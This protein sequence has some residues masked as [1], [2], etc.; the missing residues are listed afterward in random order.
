MKNRLIKVFISLV[1]A[2]VFFGAKNVGASAIVIEKEPVPT[3]I[4]YGEPLF[5]SKLIGGKANVEGAFSWANGEQL[6]EVGEHSVEVIFSADEVS[7]SPVSFFV[8]ITVNKRRV[9]IKFEDE[10]HKQYDDTRDIDLPNYIVGG[11]RKGDNVYVNGKLKGTLESGLV[12]SNTNVFLSGIELVGEKKDNYYLDLSGFS[13]KVYP[14]YIE[15]LIGDKNRVQLD[16]NMYV[17]VN[18]SIFIE[19]VGKETLKK[20]NYKIINSYDIYLASE[21]KR[22]DV[23]KTIT[24]KVKISEGNFDYERLHVYNYYNNSYEE[25]L[26]YKYEGG[27]LTYTSSSLGQLVFA[28]KELNFWW[29]YLLCSLLVVSLFSFLII[30]ILKNRKKINKYKSLKRRKDHGNY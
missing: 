20:D 30:L 4:D 2:F 10:I 26:D 15:K 13:A 18:T 11:I 1:L 7:Y 6:L 28:Q 23:D 27:Y 22:I 19:E 25:I 5:E 24:V 3:S 16:K 29:V 21:G 8:N 12:A 14:K 17:P 9:Y